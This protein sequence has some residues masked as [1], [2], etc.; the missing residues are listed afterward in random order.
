MKIYTEV[1]IDMNTLE[2][3]YEDSYEYD[4]EV[5]KCYGLSPSGG[6]TKAC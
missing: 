5:A 4:G 2:T 6:G 3:T 1:R